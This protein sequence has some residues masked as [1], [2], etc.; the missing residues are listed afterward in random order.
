MIQACFKDE[1]FTASFRNLALSYLLTAMLP[2]AGALLLGWVAACG[3]VF[4]FFFAQW[5][6]LF[7]LRYET[8][9]I[10]N[11]LED[12]H[13][14][15]AVPPAFTAFICLGA[16]TATFYI[17]WFLNRLF[18]KLL[19]EKTQQGDDNGGHD[20]DP[21]NLSRPCGTQ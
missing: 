4:S 10:I 6:L 20:H 21:K 16:L 14:L 17:L 9:T 7:P 15:I 2:M 11:Q 19:S 1:V 3:L 8:H 12:Y 18:S 5:G 13:R